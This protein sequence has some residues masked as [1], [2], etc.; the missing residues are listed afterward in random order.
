MTADFA[1]LLDYCGFLADPLA[2]GVVEAITA[3]L[4]DVADH[5]QEIVVYEYVDPVAVLVEAALTAVYCFV[6][7]TDVSV[8]AVDRSEV[9]N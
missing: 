3:F 5:P 7:M 8:E 6:Q 2:A 1:R 4:L 9:A